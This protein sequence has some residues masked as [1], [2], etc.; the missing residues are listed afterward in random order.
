[1]GDTIYS[2]VLAMI[3]QHVVFTFF[4]SE[5]YNFSGSRYYQFDP[6]SNRVTS[7][8]TIGNLFKSNGEWSIPDNLDAA[9][10]E[11]N[12]RT[13]FFFKGTKVK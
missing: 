8:G 6:V 4:Y 10:Y 13:I 7:Q 9:F 11:N 1:M 3:R 5:F 2:S 12:T